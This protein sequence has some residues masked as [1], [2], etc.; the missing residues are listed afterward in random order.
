MKITIF[1]LFFFFNDEFGLLH[2]VILRWIPHV[3]FVLQDSG[4]SFRAAVR[5]LIPQL[6]FLDDVPVEEDTA[7]RCRASLQDWTLLRE[8]IRDASLTDAD[9]QQR[10]ETDSAALEVFQKQRPGDLRVS[11]TSLSRPLTSCSGSRP[12][13][14]RSDIAVLNHEASDLTNGKLLPSAD[15]DALLF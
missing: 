13:S 4:S 2:T 10:L 8:S 11:S 9:R 15:R 7:P 14:T 3:W 12:A 6:I 5:E 1:L